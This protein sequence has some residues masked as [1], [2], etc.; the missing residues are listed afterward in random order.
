MVLAAGTDK[1]PDSPMSQFLILIA[2]IGVAF[3]LIILRPQKREQH[4]K[5]QML[6]SLDKG[7]RIVTIGG[8]HGTVVGVN[9]TKKTVSVDVGKNVRIEFSRNA[10]S[11]IEKKAGKAAEEATKDKE[12]R[13]DD[14]T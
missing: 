10:V 6:T 7:D 1:P 4:K 8:I 12:T 2:M 9:E 11:T 13:E 14:K 5:E 3:Y